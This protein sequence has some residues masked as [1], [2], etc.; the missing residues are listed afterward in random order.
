ML[1]CPATVSFIRRRR[2]RMLITTDSAAS[3]WRSL[4]PFA[5][6]WLELPAGRMHYLDEGPTSIV[7]DESKSTLLFVHGNPTW[8]FHWRNLVGALRSKYRC[9]ALDHIGCG[10]SGKPRRLL[11]LEDH[12]DNLTALVTGLNLNRITLVAQDWGGAIGLGA[13]LR[14]PERL[15]RIIL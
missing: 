4:Y 6:N 15:N 1:S 9:V 2:S 3:E 10:L 14:T 8:S 7:P 12:V 13:M 11:T 5:S